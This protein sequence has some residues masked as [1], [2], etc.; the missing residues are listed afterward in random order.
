MTGIS[1]DPLHELQKQPR[2]C[3]PWTLLQPNGL[4]STSLQGYHTEYSG[5]RA[6]DPRKWT[7]SIPVHF[8]LDGKPLASLT[9]STMAVRVS[10]RC[11]SRRAAASKPESWPTPEGG[12]SRMDAS[13]APGV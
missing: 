11:V 7:G 5:L 6:I 4:T 12:R 1:H 3:A 2:W 8:P 9:C 13:E 10:P